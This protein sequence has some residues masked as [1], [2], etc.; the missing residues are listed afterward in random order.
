MLVNKCCKSCTT[1]KCWTKYYAM[2]NHSFRL[3]S[4][5]C[6]NSSFYMQNCVF[7]LMLL[8]TIQYLAY[9]IQHWAFTIQHTYF[10]IQNS[11]SVNY[12]TLCIDNSISI[13]QI[14]FT[15]DILVLLLRK[16]KDHILNPT[17]LCL[18]VAF[19]QSNKLHIKA[20]MLEGI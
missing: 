9:I 19:F 20:W 7:K 12:S 17:F 18:H 1:T 4:Y 13:F 5:F 3:W 6:Q 14:L 11:T 10:K 8:F 15:C 2:L 16:T